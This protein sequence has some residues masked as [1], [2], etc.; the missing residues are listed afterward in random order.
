[1]DEGTVY[2]VADSAVLDDLGIRLSRGESV[3]VPM[4]RLE[5]SVDLRNARGMGLVS[6]AIPKATMTRQPDPLQGNARAVSRAAHS[7][8]QPV[9]DPPARVQPTTSLPTDLTPLLGVLRDIL[10][11]V[12]HLR[13]EVARRPLQVVSVPGVTAHTRVPVEDTTPMFIPTIPTEA[14]TVSIQQTT[15]GGSSSSLDEALNL[16]RRKK[17]ET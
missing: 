17:D 4:D 7:P 8:F 12:R 5:H 6:L 2:C 10:L 1:M 16:L 11:E 9:V 13:E 3:R 15:T 14:G